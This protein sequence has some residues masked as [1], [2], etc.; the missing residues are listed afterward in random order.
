MVP[1][2][3]QNLSKIDPGW[4]LEATWEPPLKQ[5][6]P[7]TSFLTILAPFWDPLWDQFGLVLGIIFWCFFEVAFWWPWPPFGLPKTSKMVFKRG[8]YS[9]RENHW[10]CSYLLHLSSVGR[11]KK[12]P[13]LGTILGTGFTKKRIKSGFQEITKNQFKKTLQSGPQNGTIWGS[14]RDPLQSN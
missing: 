10:F 8:F 6:A 9:R 12:R 13:S 2:W 3:S 1:K 7:K 4:A 11:L 5:G 14:F